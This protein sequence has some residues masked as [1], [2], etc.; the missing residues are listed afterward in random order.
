M[1]VQ[2]KGLPMSVDWI[3]E[4][5]R[6]AFIPINK[7]AEKADKAALRK[8]RKEERAKNAKSRL[9]ATAK[10]RA[11]SEAFDE[12]MKTRPCSECRKPT[13][14]DPEFFLNPV[15]C[16]KCKDR[17]RDIDLGIHPRAHDHFSEVTVFKGGSPGLGKRK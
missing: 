10:A 6:I 8:Q 16:Q 17:S 2:R 15:L 13:R 14:A 11:A 3:T 5:L 7:A 1:D 4:Q 9:I 12:S